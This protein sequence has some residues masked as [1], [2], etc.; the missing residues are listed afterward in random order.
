MIRLNPRLATIHTEDPRT[1]SARSTRENHT[2]PK[3]E[4]IDRDRDQSTLSQ[5][6]G[7]G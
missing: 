1:Q 4:G 3:F 6:E 5:E 2:R 7:G